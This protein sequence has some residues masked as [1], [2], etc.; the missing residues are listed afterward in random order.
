MNLAVFLN[1]ANFCYWVALTL[2]KTESVLSKK[3]LCVSNGFPSNVF[4]LEKLKL[5]HHCNV[6]H[7][8][9]LICQEG[10]SEAYSWTL[11][12]RSIT[13]IVGIR[14]IVVLKLAIHKKILHFLLEPIGD[15]GVGVKEFIFQFSE[16]LTEYRP[17]PETSGNTSG[18]RL[19]NLETL[20][21][22]KDR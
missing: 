3:I 11:P 7:I 16:R 12:L 19:L 21:V 6:S 13:P 5:R 14:R 9:E 4:G 8:G 2:A 20:I 15:M 17:F 22:G 18:S 10:V 1:K